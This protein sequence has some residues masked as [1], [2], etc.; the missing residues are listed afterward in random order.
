[1]K[2][3]V[4][5]LESH[6]NGILGVDSASRLQSVLGILGDSAGQIAMFQFEMVD[7]SM[8]HGG[9]WRMI[10][11]GK[12]RRWD[13]GERCLENMIA[14]LAEWEEWQHSQL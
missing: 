9:L 4:Q 5:Y 14:R 1:M 7:D 2:G 6:S 3:E 12:R 10:W 13:C 11:T 8:V